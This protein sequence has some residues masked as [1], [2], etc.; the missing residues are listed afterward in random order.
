MVVELITRYYEEDEAILAAEK[1]ENLDDAEKLLRQECELCTN[2]MKITEVV[3]MANCN[4]KCCKDC[5]KNYFTIAIKDKSIAEAACPFCQEPKG[6]NNDEN[7]DKAAEY[8][9]KLDV[10]LKG[11][12]EEEVHDLFQ[13]KLR[14]RT[15]MKDPNFKWC[16][17]VKPL[18]IIDS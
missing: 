6:L 5:A 8:F 9:A 16:Y 17:K 4:H 2:G 10:L 12:I 7:E 3:E 11:I 14:D 1:S 18:Y 15:L 13:R